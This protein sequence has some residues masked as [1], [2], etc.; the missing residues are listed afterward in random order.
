[1]K[2]YNSIHDIN[3][4]EEVILTPFYKLPGFYKH[5]TL[6]LA[7]NKEGKVYN[8][9]TGNFIKVLTDPDGRQRIQYSDYLNNKLLHFNKRLHRLLAV[10][11]IGRPKIHLNKP[12]NKLEVNHIDGN[13]N[14]NSLDNL[15]WCTGKENTNHYFDYSQ[16][17]SGKILFSKN[18]HTGEVLKHRSVS[19]ASRDLKINEGGLQRYIKENRHLKY[20]YNNYFFSFDEK[21]FV[22]SNSQSTNPPDAYQDCIVIDLYFNNKYIFGS[23]KEGADFINMEYKLLW[24]HLKTKRKYIK[25]NF[26]ITR[27]YHY[28]EDNK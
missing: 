16:D 4:R 14:N 10:I 22:E 18:Y 26:L 6:P 25:D 9:K 5:P 7:L 20:R 27:L 24:Y 8:I 3:D 2:T 23:I 17:T 19:Q 11:F 15:E 13:N 12:F 1:M 28:I 21:E